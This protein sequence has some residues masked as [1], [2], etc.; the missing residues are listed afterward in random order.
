M[1]N[2]AVGKENRRAV[3]SA[4]ALPPASIRRLDPRYSVMDRCG[5]SAGVWRLGDVYTGGQG[6]LSQSSA[7]RWALHRPRG[8]EG[9][10]VVGG[11]AV[12][13][14]SS[15]RSERIYIYDLPLP[16]PPEEE[17]PRH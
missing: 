17:S 5:C 10:E 4:R 13:V 1:A 6:Q 7:C 12:R 14:T 16:G 8:I 15:N 11:L 3:K 2:D 9:D